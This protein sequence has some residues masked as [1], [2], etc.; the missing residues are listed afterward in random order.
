MDEPTQRVSLPLEWLSEKLMPD[1]LAAIAERADQRGRSTADQVVFAAT[2]IEGLRRRGE[3]DQ[4]GIVEPHADLAG[5]HLI[6]LLRAEARR[7]RA[8]EED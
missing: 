6:E 3:L 7:L 4:I 5:A 1:L 2:M 8:A